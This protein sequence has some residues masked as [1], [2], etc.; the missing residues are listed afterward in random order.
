MTTSLSPTKNLPIFHREDQLDDYRQ[1]YDTTGEIFRL[2]SSGLFDAVISGE[3]DQKGI[4]ED[5]ELTDGPHLN[6]R[7]LPRSNTVV[8]ENFELMHQ[9]PT[10][11]HTQVARGFLRGWPQLP[12]DTFT[13]IPDTTPFRHR[14]A[15]H[16]LSIFRILASAF[17]ESLFQHIEHYPPSVPDAQAI[18]GLVADEIL[19]VAPLA[20]LAGECLDDL[21]VDSLLNQ[22]KNVTDA[23]V[24][25]HRVVSF[26]A[27]GRNWFPTWQFGS[28]PKQ[29]LPV[30]PQIVRLFRERSEA[31][32]TNE[33]G[34][35]FDYRV[36]LLRWAGESQE[37]LE[38]L[39]PTQWIAAQR[40]EEGLLASIAQYRYQPPTTP[41]ATS[42][43]QTSIVNPSLVENDQT[44]EYSSQ[45]RSIVGSDTATKIPKMPLSGDVKSQN[46]SVADLIPILGSVSQPSMQMLV[47]RFL[48]VLPSVSL[49]WT[50]DVSILRNLGS[51]I[52]D[53]IAIGYTVFVHFLMEVLKNDRSWDTIQNET[54]NWL[55]GTA[56][57]YA[58]SKAFWIVAV[59]PKLTEEELI[60]SGY[61]TDTELSNFTKE[62]R[63]LRY[64]G[65]DGF[66][67]P[68][69][70]FDQ[71]T[72]EI[73]PVLALLQDIF[74]MGPDGMDE[75]S[76]ISWASQPRGELKGLSAA[77]W[78]E[79]GNDP[80]RVL[81]AAHS[82]A[83]LIF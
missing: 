55:G 67:Y 12:E 62:H 34:L 27:F 76:I 41:E 77:E 73:R 52:M 22:R 75:G 69:W 39:P 3:F 35:H 81:E 48:H 50:Q 9:L 56:G 54:A 33:P 5:A 65:Y 6:A 45:S 70:Q 64:S 7:Q 43:P 46:G 60:Q 16:R 14:I 26:P 63:L 78:I 2:T 19:A 32:E 74:R 17:G 57:K 23:Q 1:V 37:L 38:G 31:V 25:E 68:R 59:K 15:C 24:A 51:S 47:R 83:D 44:V 8:S 30:V 21:G 20:D 42:F 18:A 13:A 4:G 79:K 71:G 58:A 53:G 49:D 66:W 36:P 29:I 80:N 61:C 40:D 82:L 72:T 10:E 11:Q 28:S